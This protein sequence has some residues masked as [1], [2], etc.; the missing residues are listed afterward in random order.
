MKPKS[1]KC[2]ENFDVY[3]LPIKSIVIYCNLK[4]IKWVF[5]VTMIF[6]F[7]YSS[8]TLSWGRVILKHSLSKRSIDL[9]LYMHPVEVF[10]SDDLKEYQV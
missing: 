3:T 2:I 9:Y 10:I 1:G 7:S 8:P 4:I 6:I 5:A